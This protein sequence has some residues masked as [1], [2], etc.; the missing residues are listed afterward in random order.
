MSYK[1]TRTNGIQRLSDGA[2]LPARFENG[3]LIELDPHSPFVKELRKWIAEGNAPLPADPVPPPVPVR[4]LVDEFLD[5][6]PA[7]RA[8]LKAELAKP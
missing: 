5:L 2:T 6:P 8:A 3:Q 4:D 1:L 7:R